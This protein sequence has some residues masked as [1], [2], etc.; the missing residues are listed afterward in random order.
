MSEN[1][2]ASEHVHHQAA[3]QI[4]WAYC[5]G[6]EAGAAAAGGGFTGGTKAAQ[7]ADYR[8]KK[9]VERERAQG[10]GSLFADL[11]KDLKD[12]EASL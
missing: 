4:G 12:F 8:E 1:S 5:F 3:W 10:L 9:V 11:E 7:F 6:R 2:D